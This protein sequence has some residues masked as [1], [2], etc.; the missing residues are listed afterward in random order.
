MSTTKTLSVEQL[1]KA[2]ARLS[3]QERES[4]IDLLDKKNLK[5][6]RT[7]VH[8]Q[9]AKRQTVTERALFKGLG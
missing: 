8:R 7:L 6:R 9:I 4:L 5:K 3:P 2:L 1:A